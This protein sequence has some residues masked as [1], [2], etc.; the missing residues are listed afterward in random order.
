[1]LKRNRR[2]HQSVEDLPLPSRK[3]SLSPPALDLPTTLQASHQ[4]LQLTIMKGFSVAMIIV[5]TPDV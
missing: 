5:A 1:V 4:P 2:S 3:K